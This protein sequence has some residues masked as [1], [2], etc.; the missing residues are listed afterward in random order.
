MNTI[1]KQLALKVPPIRKIYTERESLRSEV[2][3]K[4]TRI[5]QLRSDL[6]QAQEKAAA[7]SYLC[8]QGKQEAVVRSKDEFL[9]YMEAFHLVIGDSLEKNLAKNAL[10][11]LMEPVKYWG[12]AK[13]AASQSTYSWI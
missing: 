10:I 11:V 5:E 9:R 13:Y 2:F 1:I 3:S 4:D 12:S 7:L 8:A 6:E